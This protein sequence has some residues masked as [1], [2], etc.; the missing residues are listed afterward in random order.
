MVFT[1]GSII[2]ITLLMAYVGQER[3]LYEFL[4]HTCQYNFTTK[5]RFNGAMR[6]AHRSHFLRRHL[7]IRMT[8]RCSHFAIN[9]AT[10]FPHI[11]SR[12][13]MWYAPDPHGLQ[14][15]CVPRLAPT[16]LVCHSH[17]NESPL[18]VASSL[19]V[20]FSLSPTPTLDGADI[21]V[22]G[23]ARPAHC[24]CCLCLQALAPTSAP[25]S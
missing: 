8:L 19:H 9:F 18:T 23:L 12:V 15:P 5:S 3:P 4:H 14:K 21:G 1:A 25:D 22:A 10:F 11:L 20:L 7:K 16:I 24:C 17:Y 6:N 2:T 13:R